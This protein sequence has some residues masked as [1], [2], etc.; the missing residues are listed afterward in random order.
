[1]YTRRSMFKHTGLAALASAL[2]PNRNLGQ[3]Q[4]VRS[5]YDQKLP[6]VLRIICDG[7]WDQ[8]M[9]FDPQFSSTFVERERD[10][11]LKW[12]GNLPLAFAPARPATDRFFEK[13]SSEILLLNGVAF[14]SLEHQSAQRSFQGVTS[15]ESGSFQDYLGYYAIKRTPH[16][17]IPHLRID[18]DPIPNGIYD[19]HNIDLS[20]TN[21]RNMLMGASDDRASHTPSPEVQNYL[22]QNYRNMISTSEG[23][24]ERQRSWRIYRSYAHELEWNQM[25]KQ[26]TE[27]VG[28]DEGRSPFFRNTLLSLALMSKGLTSCATMRHGEPLEWDSKGNF[29]EN[30]S[31]LF[32][33]LFTDLFDLL[34]RP[35]AASIR[36]R[37]YI[38]VGSERGRGPKADTQG[39]K[40]HTSSTSLLMMGPSIKSNIVIGASDSYLQSTK[41]AFRSH[42]RNEKPVLRDLRLSNI[43][44]TLFDLW[45][46][47]RSGILKTEEPIRLMME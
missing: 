36:D 21:I 27:G 34:L 39:I 30:Q 28:Y 46:C 20:S 13:Y 45:G 42:D 8:S 32:E 31:K 6:L 37:L 24:T 4:S 29:F 16:F 3:A 41:I 2:L 15:S 22:N 14:S 11:S 10:L 1:M 38:M 5:I 47:E 35:E 44:A 9:V 17:K 43:Y 18:L 26:L 7:G 33:S 40:L 25:R 19:E 12:Y 23:I